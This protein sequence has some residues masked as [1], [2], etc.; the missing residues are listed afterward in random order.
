[1][2]G[3]GEV[4]IKQFSDEGGSAYFQIIELP[5]VRRTQRI[6]KGQNFFNNPCPIAKW[7]HGKNMRE[8]D[9]VQ[10]CGA[11]KGWPD[12]LDNDWSESSQQ[13]YKKVGDWTVVAEKKTFTN[14]SLFIP[15][16]FL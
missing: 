11:V 12:W 4:I 16:F 5:A 9:G 7:L 1:M 13:E 3:Q 2:Y 8:Q 10:F 15:N 6:T 14:L